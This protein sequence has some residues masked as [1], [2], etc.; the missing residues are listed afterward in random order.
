LWNVPSISGSTEESDGL[1][2]SP[3]PR[4]TI[5]LEPQPLH[6][7]SSPEED[8]ASSPVADAPLELDW[9]SQPLSG[10][11]LA[12]T[13]DCLVVVASLLLF[14]LVFLSVTHELP[15]WPLSLAAGFGAVILVV[16][17]YCGFSFAFGGATLGARLARLTGCD[18]EDDDAEDTDRFR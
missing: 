14:G 7:E 5:Q 4:K 18:Q 11:S 2:V 13:V 1:I 10:R 6:I 17:L 8:K 12:W 16:A 9:L 3:A 15:R